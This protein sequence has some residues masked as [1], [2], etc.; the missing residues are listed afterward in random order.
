MIHDT[1]IWLVF[2]RFAVD[3]IR[4]SAGAG[5][6]E[7]VGAIAAVAERLMDVSEDF[8]LRV[9]LFFAF[10]RIKFFRAG[11]YKPSLHLCVLAPLRETLF[12]PKS[13]LLLCVPSRLLRSTLPSQKLHEIEE[14]D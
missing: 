3:M 12:N 6:V 14:A 9:R 10:L 11:F 4:F 5:G 13:S 2:S 1:R 7:A 8:L